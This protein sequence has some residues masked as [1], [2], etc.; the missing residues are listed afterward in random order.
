MSSDDFEEVDRVPIQYVEGFPCVKLGLNEDA[1]RKVLTMK[2]MKGDI[3]L[4]TYPKCGTTWTQYIMWEIMNQGVPPPNTN[5]LMYKDMPFLEVTG[6]EALD[7]LKEPRMY[8]LHLPLRLTPW[9]PEAKYISVMRNP[10]DCCVS[11]YHH[12]NE[13]EL[14][15]CRQKLRFDSFVK[16]FVTGDLTFGSYFEHIISFF[17]KRNEPNVLFFSYESA[18][19]K[20][21]ET[22]TMIAEF[23]GLEYKAQ[24]EE[25]PE[26]M[27]R[28]LKYSSFQYM[29]EH[30]DFKI[31]SSLEAMEAMGDTY[32][33]MSYDPV[34]RKDTRLFMSGNFYRKGEVGS[35]KTELNDEQWSMIEKAIE[36]KVK[37]PELKAMMYTT[38][39]S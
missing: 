36:E 13:L 21:K 39:P 4:N 1:F 31:A 35:G 33:K 14:F 11:F 28:I 15:P 30:N 26:L 20:P 3:I 10:F 2:P 38:K 23:M 18:K 37:D 34:L 6:I 12:S 16:D 19:Q 9:N 27:E 25:D 17:E 5:Q 29:K 24:L 22:I 8:K 7:N 32:V